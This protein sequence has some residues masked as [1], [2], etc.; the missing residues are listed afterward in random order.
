[1]D[2]E[3]LFEGEYEGNVFKVVCVPGQPIEIRVNFGTGTEKYNEFEIE[4]ELQEKAEDIRHACLNQSWKQLMISAERTAI[5]AMI[6]RGIGK[7]YS[8]IGPIPK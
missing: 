6:L 1:M 7:K 2:Q 3:T 5:F 8:K 4:E